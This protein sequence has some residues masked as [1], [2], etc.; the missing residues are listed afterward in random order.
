[1]LSLCGCENKDREDMPSEKLK[2]I[3]TYKTQIGVAYFYDIRGE[4]WVEYESFDTEMLYPV[5]K[6]V[7]YLYG[8]E[9]LA[10][11]DTDDG[12]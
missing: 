1:M 7:D 9:G 10:V 5:N 6:S 4:L 2:P 3:M 12:V 11:G 8:I